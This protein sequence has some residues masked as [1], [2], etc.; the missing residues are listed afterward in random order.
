MDRFA[1]ERPLQS[2]WAAIVFAD[3]VD[4]IGLIQTDERGMVERIRH[5]LASIA[6]SVVPSFGGQV[7]E[8][9]GDGLLLRFA[10]A[11]AALRCAVVMQAHRVGDT[12]PS[13]SPARDIRLRV[14]VH[15]GEVLTDGNAL[16]GTAINLAARLLTVA[17]A[18]DIVFT[19]DVH[20][21]AAAQLQDLA[22]HDMGWCYLK[23]WREPVHLWRLQS[24]E[25][26]ASAVRD[27]REP[28]WRARLA[29]LPFS[30]QGTVSAPQGLQDFLVDTLIA[31]LSRHPGV[32]VTSRL[33]AVSAALA[34]LSPAAVAER[35]GVRY[36]VTGSSW[37]MGQRL[38]LVVHL[39]DARS[40]ELLWTERV[41]GDLAD[42]LQPDSVLV[43]GVVRGCA[44][45]LLQSQV[46]EAMTTP[47]PQLDSHALMTG[48]VALMHRAAEAD[49]RRSEVMLHAV[50]ERHR[51][52][53]SPRA[54]LAKWHVLSAV[55][56]LDERGDALTQAI[57]MAD[58]ALD[59]E[60]S[61]A[62][63]LSVKG[64]ALCHQGARVDEAQRLLDD[65][66]DANPSEPM[67]WLY[68]SVWHQMWGDG[69][70]AV[71]DAQHAIGLS[72]LDPQLGYFEMMLGI[73]HLANHDPE[74]ALQVCEAV[75]HKV[76]RQLPLLRAL[77]V[78]QFEVGDVAAARKSLNI[79]RA[80]APDMTVT[81]FLASVQASPFRRRVAKTMQ[82]LGLPDH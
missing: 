19:H 37:L 28:D 42:L 14:A 47:L 59:L 49:L 26:G 68:R 13:H 10:D 82:S 4:S 15:A 6:R 63:A 38:G 44:A 5:L 40:D 73:S 1:E 72:P 17:T 58:R 79:I 9:Q 60:P 32:L 77:L 8:R 34:S 48:A 80:L 66:V 54:W 56:G 3:V 78:A 69:R 36:L 52:I 18:G 55:Q 74:R 43:G 31:G 33:S 23:H 41:S 30:M 29:V 11:G 75:I 39:L 64:H 45:A 16:Y 21:L 50:I 35:L 24:P 70:L 71:A 22:P 62:L 20:A 2:D 12:S 51:H 67:A 81:S 65:A 53:A 7:L 57:D 46:R 61:A 76:P 25:G 27:E